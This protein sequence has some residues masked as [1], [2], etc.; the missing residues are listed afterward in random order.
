MQ[1]PLPQIQMIPQQIQQL[2][3]IQIQPSGL[4]AQ[5]QQQTQY[6]TSQDTQQQIQN[7][8]QQQLAMQQHAQNN[9][10]TSQA[11]AAQIQ[12]IT[13]QP[14]KQ[15]LLIGQ[16]SVAQSQASMENRPIMTMVS[17]GGGGSGIVSAGANA[18]NVSNTITSL[19]AMQ[20]LGSHMSAQQHL[21][22]Q[23]PPNPL[24]AMTSLSYSATPSA[25][26]TNSTPNMAKDDKNTIKSDNTQTTNS[27]S[28]SEPNVLIS[29][30][31]TNGTTVTT[32]ANGSITISS[33][34]STPVTSL[35]A[36]TSINKPIGKFH[37]TNF[38]SM[39]KKEKRSHSI[40]SILHFNLEPVKSTI[41]ISTNKASP[42]KAA[43]IHKQAEPMKSTPTATRANNAPTVVPSK[44]SPKKVESPKPVESPKSTTMDKPTLTPA[45]PSAQVN[46]SKKEETASPVNGANSKSRTP[47]PTIPAS[48]N[49][50]KNDKGLLPKA[51][52]KPN[53]LT[54]VIDGHVIQEGTQPFPVTPKRLSDD[55]EDPVLAKRSKSSPEKAA[56]TPD[57]STCTQCGKKD[58][59]GKLK[60]RPYC[61]KTCS[62][63]AKAG[64]VPTS[65]QNG[66]HKLRIRNENGTTN[67][68]VSP[69]SLPS[70]TSTNGTSSDSSLSASSDTSSIDA[71]KSDKPAPT[72]MEITPEQNDADQEERR[73]LLL[74]WS[75][76][77]V[78]DYIRSL[79]SYSD[80]ADEFMNHEIDGQALVLL[81]ENHLVKT[82]GIK[83]G[84]ALKIMSQIRAI[85]TNGPPQ[86]ES[87][88]K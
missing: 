41:T 72:P 32:V 39:P 51:M 79:P 2:Q 53:V 54:H 86:T 47:T 43:E 60:Y 21:P 18:N 1:Q 42:K 37:F 26:L 59:K 65:K 3:Q 74:R 52:I 8:L 13:I 38:G 33:A 48:L 82:M 87:Q 27:L 29:T 22:I 14:P 55:H 78:V 40:N 46:Q 15:P 19:N 75:V 31:S 20:H 12:Q 9:L 49:L 70:P 17:I 80:Y 34:T 35:A 56:T 58:N 24:A 45:Q 76:D 11:N 23:P 16:Q 63:H 6:V 77:E 69:K 67:G 71:K 44:P 88:S 68:S 62:K 66:E 61:S 84:P 57:R 10:N 73:A 5:G 25:I 36:N 85:T 64:V 83:L 50:I 4:S 81:N 30:S 28:T 7:Q